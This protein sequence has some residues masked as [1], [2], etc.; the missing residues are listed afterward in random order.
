MQ[1][2]LYCYTFYELIVTVHLTLITHRLRASS[3]ACPWNSSASSTGQPAARVSI[4]VR[5]VDRGIHPE[6]SCSSWEFYLVAMYIQLFRFS[7]LINNG[8]SWDMIPYR[9][10]VYAKDHNEKMIWPYQITVFSYR[11]GYHFQFRVISCKRKSIVGTIRNVLT[12]LNV[13]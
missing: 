1:K 3:T 5:N 9:L 13:G 11:R 7:I 4:I 8:S 2:I 10:L 6:H 12:A